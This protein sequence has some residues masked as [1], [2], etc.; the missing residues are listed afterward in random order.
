M[1][2]NLEQVNKYYNY[3]KS[4]QNHALRDINLK[5]ND[6]E[7]VAVVGKSGAGKST[8]MHILACI[9]TFESGSYKLNGISI[10]ELSDRKISTIRNKQIGIVLQSFALVEGYTVLNNVMTSLFFSKIRSN[11]KRETMAIHALRQVD[12]EEL[13]LSKVNKISGGERQRTG[14]A[15]AIVNSPSILIADEPTGALDIETSKETMKVF[16]AL[17][18]LGMTVIIVTHDADIFKICDRVIEIS[19][20]QIISDKQ[21][22]IL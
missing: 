4:N 18:A 8:L 7:F 13:A 19:N 22:N 9:D 12:I 3:K 5:I 15:R 10:S 17:N 11:I 2:I 1:S 6:G 21:L 16:K 20:G 14:I